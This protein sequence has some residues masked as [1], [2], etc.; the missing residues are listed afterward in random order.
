MITPCINVGYSITNASKLRKSLKFP[1]RRRQTTE[2]VTDVLRAPNFSHQ[3]HYNLPTNNTTI[4]MKFAAAATV[5]FAASA[6]AF[7]PATTGN[8]SFKVVR[9]SGDNRRRLWRHI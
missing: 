7:A 3:L 2:E 8:V 9:R 6:N 4:K 1:K 5:A